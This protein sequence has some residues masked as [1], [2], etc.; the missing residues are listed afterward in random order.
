MPWSY[1]RALVNSALEREW[2][3]IGE[4]DRAGNETACPTIVHIAL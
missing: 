4:A 3:A 1:A 2:G